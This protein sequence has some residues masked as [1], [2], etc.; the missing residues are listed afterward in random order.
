MSVKCSIFLSGFALL[1]SALLVVAKQPD[2]LSPEILSTGGGEAVTRATIRCVSDLRVADL[3]DADPQDVVVSS[4]LAVVAPLSF[5]PM[6]APQGLVVA[7]RAARSGLGILDAPLPTNSPAMAV[8]FAGPGDDNTRIPPS[9]QIAAGPNHLMVAQNN[10]VRIMDRAGVVLETLSMAQFWTPLG[11]KVVVDQPRL[12]FDA[13]AQRFIFLAR[14]DAL[15]TNSALFLAVTKTSDPMAGWNYYKYDADAVAHQLWADNTGLGFSKDWVVLAANRWTM[16]GLG[17]NTIVFV[18]D[19]TNLYA[20]GVGTYTNFVMGNLLNLQPAVNQDANSTATYLMNAY[21]TNAVGAPHSQLRL[22]SITGSVSAPVLVPG[23]AV[24][25]GVF[26][27]GSRTNAA[28]FAPQ[29]GST[30]KIQCNDDKLL[31]VVYR[32]GHLWTAHTVFFPTNQPVARSS[33]QWWEI[34]PATTGI[35]QRSTIDDPSGQYFY[36]FPSIGVNASNDVLLGYSRF[37]TGEYATAAYSF[38]AATDGLDNVRSNAVL[39]AGLASYYKT[40]DGVRN[41]WG[42]YGAT[43]VDPANDLSFWT[44]QEYAQTGNTN[45][46]TWIGR[47]DAPVAGIEWTLAQTV[48]TPYPVAGSNCV[49]TIVVSNIT[50]AA[51]STTVLDVLSSGLSYSSYS[52]TMGT[53]SFTGTTG[54]WSVGSLLAG[55]AATLTLNCA[56]GGATVRQALTSVASVGNLSPVSVTVIPIA[57]SGIGNELLVSRTPAGVPGNASSHYPAMTPDGRYTAFLSSASDLLLGGDTNGKADVFVYDRLLGAMTRASV[58]SSGDEANGD[59]DAPAISSDGRYVSFPSLA[60]NLVAGDTNGLRDVFVKD[61][62]NGTVTCVSVLPGGAIGPG[63][64]SVIYGGSL[65]ANGQVCAYEFTAPLLPTDNNSTW[66]AYVYDFATGSNELVSVNLSGQSGNS[67]SRGPALS[68]DGRYVAFYSFANDLVAGDSNGCNDIFLYDRQTK[69][70]TRVSVSSSGAQ[71]NGDSM[72]PMI[73]GNGR[74]VIFD[75][76]ATNLTATDTASNNCTYLRDTVAGTTVLIS[77]TPAGAAA[78]HDGTLS[79]ISSDGRYLIFDSDADNLVSNDYNTARDVFYLDRTNG[80]LRR[81]S[82]TTAGTEANAASRANYRPLISDNGRWVAFESDASNLTGSD[83]NGATDVFVRDMWD[84]FNGN[85]VPDQWELQYF[86][87]TNVV[88]ATS[89]YDRDGLRDVGEYL[90]GTDPTNS[91]S[92]LVIVSIE[93]IYGTNVTAIHVYD[94]ALD[95]I[96]GTNYPGY[97]YTAA[98]QRFYSVIG[99]TL[100]WSSVSNRIYGLRISTNLNTDISFSQVLATNLITTAPTNTYFDAV[101]SGVFRRF[102]RVIVEAGF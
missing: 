100:K 60:S 80:T 41:R 53:L 76:R 9:P 40:G 93:S 87:A 26:S 16:A 66:D 82:L 4:P 14:S 32:N 44:I 91:N 77:K 21:N 97:V 55:Q 75:S 56:V 54:T 7:P 58:T 3:R 23:A 90:A 85:G 22:Y 99:E 29:L 1:S 28:D 8:T 36:A 11:A 30:N 25:D 12:V 62:V 33:I 31:N 88:T 92:K 84:D 34:N 74:Y 68:A 102:Y 61:L 72:R 86:G 43:V 89:D 35:V 19:K 17:S 81:V 13:A 51:V 20:G 94:G 6:L 96:L 39:K 2:S 15:T 45:W 67:V 52:A 70:T 69:T 98:T 48:N 5:D 59:S 46:G 65:S 24:A 95:P 47:L 18:M 27:W 57:P 83:N 37:S 42:D 101:V 78:N 50:A 73:S 38:H 79:S 71:A 49:F 64:G 63:S 10:N